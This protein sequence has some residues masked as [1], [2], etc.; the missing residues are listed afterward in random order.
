MPAYY[1][2]ITIREYYFVVALL[3]R[4][5]LFHD[6]VVFYS[7]EH[8]T[9]RGVYLQLDSLLS[10]FQHVPNEQGQL[11]IPTP[12]RSNAITEMFRRRRDWNII[13]TDRRNVRSY[14]R[15]VQVR[16]IAEV[17]FLLYF[18]FF[19]P[20][21]STSASRAVL[22]PLSRSQTSFDPLTSKTD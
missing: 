3:L 11:E 12:S 21:L 9:H 2:S 4:R 5:C 6:I 8:E 17:I 13:H 19:L 20:N 22:S 16:R 10:R 18:F 14:R 1:F 15:L 7:T